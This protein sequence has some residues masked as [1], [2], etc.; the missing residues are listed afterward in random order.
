MFVLTGLIQSLLV[1]F[2]RSAITG[3][4]SWMR[5]LQSAYFW[6]AGPPL[7]AGIYLTA[8]AVAIDDWKTLTSTDNLDVA[9]E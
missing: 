7:L 6:A 4:D 5:P 3:V 8:V 2:L 1:C 9:P